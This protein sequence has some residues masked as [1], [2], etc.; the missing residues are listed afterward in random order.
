MAD[1]TT[2]K[3]APP[4]AATDS[5]PKGVDAGNAFQVRRAGKMAAGGSHVAAAVTIDELLASE[6]RANLKRTRETAREDAVKY[7]PRVP[8]PPAKIVIRPSHAHAWMTPFISLAV[9]LGISIFLCAGAI[10][11]LFLRSPAASMAADTEIRS[12]RDSMAQ[13]R[14]AVAELSA[15]AA[16]NRSALDTANKLENDRF[17]RLT[18][19]PHRTERNQLIPAKKI[20]RPPE[21]NVPGAP[22][23]TAD[24]T[25]EFTGT[26]QPLQPPT[27]AS[28]EVLTGW[29]V[30]RAYDG[31]AVLEGPFGI[32]EV[33]LGQ[34]VPNLGRIQE[35]KYENNRWQVLTSKGVV[36]PAR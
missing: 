18:A 29:H 9:V 5:R 30:R 2:N 32:I 26:I 28:R 3:I 24:S 8:V 25:T 36:L 33:G 16:A 34:D 21:E 6:A 10:A 27:N 4:V 15:N 23:T 1:A 31:A 20:E 35:I 13:L 14:R 12:L 17:T 7:T 22:S 19:S 11:H